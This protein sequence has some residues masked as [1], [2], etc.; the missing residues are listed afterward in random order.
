MARGTLHGL[1]TRLLSVII[2]RGISGLR[3]VVTIRAPYGR[4]GKHA[5][6]RSH[7]HA[8]ILTARSCFRFFF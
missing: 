2:A 5:H 7:T 8:Q 4:A 6:T 1:T 3:C